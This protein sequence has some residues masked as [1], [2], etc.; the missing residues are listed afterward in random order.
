V[1]DRKVTVVGDTV[2]L[3][4]E[5]SELVAPGV[6][7]DFQSVPVQTGPN[8]TTPPANISFTESLTAA[9]APPPPEPKGLFAFRIPW[10]ANLKKD[11]ELEK[12]TA[13]LVARVRGRSTETGRLVTAPI[14][15]QLF[16]QAI[17]VTK[18]P[19]LT[20]IMLHEFASPNAAG[21][22]VFDPK[23]VEDFVGT[24][25]VPQKK[26]L[27][28]KAEANPDGRLVVFITF[29][30][31]TKKQ[32]RMFA[33]NGKGNN[34]IRPNA[35]F[36]VFHCRDVTKGGVTVVCHTEHFVVHFLNGD[37]QK[38]IQTKAGPK[39]Q[40][41]NEYMQKSNEDPVE[42]KLGAHLPKPDPDS[43]GSGGHDGVIW[44]TPFRPD[45]TSIMPGNFIH[46]I[47][48]TQGC[49]MLF[50]NYNWPK[51][52]ANEFDRVYRRWRATDDRPPRTV[53]FS[54]S[55]A[56]IRALEAVT[57]PGGRSYNFSNPPNTPPSGRSTSFEKFIAFDKNFAHLWFYHE[58]VG[59][60]YFSTTF[61]HMAKR[62]VRDR[63]VQ[64]INDLN[65]HGLTFEN[66]ILLD[67]G[68]RPPAF[69]LPDE[70]SFAG[71]DPKDRSIEDK[72]TFQPDDSLW[73]DNA[74]G[75]RTS[76]GFVGTVGFEKTVSPDV[77]KTRSWA[78]LFF[79]RE[80]DVD[81]R[82]GRPLTQASAV[83]VPGT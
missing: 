25:S 72:R 36:T 31:P 34:S 28:K 55:A 23:P 26:T 19:K 80:D 66:T 54:G 49:W 22:V 48:N 78:D 41:P 1:A 62:Y 76:A 50:R 20:R 10:K 68:K 21:D 56:T 18:D 42:Y 11:A 7:V 77:L 58:I 29:Y 40:L 32:L 67:E 82:P 47:V 44:S 73:R 4:F 39:R 70:G 12:R 24:L 16:V 27:V 75:F 79:Y 59:I 37:T 52:V 33:D 6:E 9:P 63:S 43:G 83:V 3:L 2:D 65:P 30:D 8:Q 17:D 35:T 15:E 60:K 69:N 57:E 45:G 61:F 5:T 71:Y 53:S 81:L 46:G 14:R 13:V 51:S 38:F 64:V 74:L